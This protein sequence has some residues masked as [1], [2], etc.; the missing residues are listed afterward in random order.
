LLV[1]LGLTSL[2]MVATAGFFTANRA[3]IGDRGTEVETNV[4]AR[5]VA[6]VLVRDL[7]LG[8][9]CLPTTGAFVAMD[10]EDSGDRD[11]VTTRTGITRDDLTCI[12]SATRTN[13]AQGSKQIDVEDTAG[14]EPGMR[15]YIRGT[16]GVGEFFTIEAVSDGSRWISSGS[17]LSRQY[18]ATSG[19]YAVDERR[20][21]IEEAG[22]ATPDLMLQVGDDDPTPFATGVEKMDIQYQLK[23]NCPTCDVVDIPNSNEWPLV[24]QLFLTVTV[25]SDK[26]K[27]D[28]EFYRRTISLG[29][30]PR[31]FL[32]Q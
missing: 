16:S 26:P 15:A 12:R 30:K 18:L 19:V 5:L 6:D 28:G 24:E 4:T 17:G 8:G 9:A 20:Y 1:S 32:P 22:D 23:R 27:R 31:N 2:V 25:R 10:G 13:V 7:R 14:F 29:V 3:F 21:F 11:D